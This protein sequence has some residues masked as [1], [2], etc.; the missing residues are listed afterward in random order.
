MFSVS[1]QKIEGPFLDAFVGCF[2]CKRASGC[3]LAALADWLLPGWL[4]FACWSPDFPGWLPGTLRWWVSLGTRKIEKY[5]QERTYMRFNFRPTVYTINLLALLACRVLFTW[6]W[7]T[8]IGWR[9]ILLQ[10]LISS[11]GCRSRWLGL[12]DF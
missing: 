9:L 6:H 4:G 3:L 12:E 8:M 11:S 7:H 2:F 5:I 10:L 1:E